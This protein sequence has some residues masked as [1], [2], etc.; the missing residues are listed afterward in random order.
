MSSG[1]KKVAVVIASDRVSDVGSFP[2]VGRL[3]IEVVHVIP[4]RGLSESYNR[5]IVEHPADIYLFVHDDVTFEDPADSLMKIVEGLDTYD[6]VACAGA[7]KYASWL[8]FWNAAVFADH[9]RG[10]LMQGVSGDTFKRS[11]EHTSEL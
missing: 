11:E 8:P 5:A 10:R 1:L 3:D 6:I 7:S 4:R 2:S 9:F